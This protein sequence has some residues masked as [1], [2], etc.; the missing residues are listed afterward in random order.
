MIV[1]T[2]LRPLIWV[3]TDPPEKEF[4]LSTKMF[5]SRPPTLMEALLTSK[6]FYSLG[7]SQVSGRLLVAELNLP[8]PRVLGKAEVSGYALQ[9]TTGFPTARNLNWKGLHF[10]NC[11]LRR[12]KVFGGKMLDCIFESCD[13][14]RA[15]LWNAAV[16]GCYFNSCNIN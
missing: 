7:L 13:L 12:L 3:T 14:S 1:T 9:Q 15:G 16:E 10:R 5:K 4:F 6:G 8:Q 2:A 11:D